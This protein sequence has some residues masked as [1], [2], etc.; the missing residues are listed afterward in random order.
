MIRKIKFVIPTV[1][2]RKETEIHCVE[3]ICHQALKH[4]PENEVHMVCNFES[5]EFDQ[6]KPKNP[7]IQKHVSHL[8]H[9]ISKALNVIAKQENTKDFDYFCFVQSDVFFDDTTWIEKCIEVYETH[10]NVGVIGTRPHSAFEHYNIPI[11][12]GTNTLYE[13]LWTDG[14]M[15]FSTK[16]FEEIGYFDEEFF[17]DCESEDFCYRA[18]VKGYKN[19]YIPGECLK[20]KHKTVDFTKKSPKTDLLLKSVEKSQ[21]LRFYKWQQLFKTYLKP[22]YEKQ[23]KLYNNDSNRG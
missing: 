14:I 8:M 2:A 17:G 4:N 10:D 12:N 20:F 5:L 9:S 22:I 6:W 11:T 7:Q 1:F 23:A 15:F 18:F 3:T 16:L 19:I 21:T 13:V